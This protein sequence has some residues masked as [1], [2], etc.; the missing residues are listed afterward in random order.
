MYERRA[1]NVEWEGLIR[2]WDDKPRRKH[3]SKGKGQGQEA[4]R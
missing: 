3:I 2:V 1:R 4:G